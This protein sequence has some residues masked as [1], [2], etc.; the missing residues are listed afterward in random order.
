MQIAGWLEPERLLT[1]ARGYADKEWLIIVLI[2]LQVILFTFALAGASFLWV[3]APIYSPVMSTF[4]LVTGGTLGGI[5]AYLFSRKLTDE[6]IH[7]VE[8]S[9]IYKLLQKEDNFVTLF[10]LRVMPAF[11]HSVINYSSGILNIKLKSF[12]PAAIL[13]IGIKSYIF[14]SVIHKATTT[15]SLR[16]LLDFSTY[17]PLLLISLSIFATILIRYKLQHKKSLN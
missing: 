3:A 6:W 16:D 17:G 11:P 10:A 2:L 8:N 4:I 1:L 12:I 7:R 9:H 14:S 13:G 15:A 5:A